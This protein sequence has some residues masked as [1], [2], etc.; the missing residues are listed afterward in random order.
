[1]GQ[2][3]NKIL[4]LETKFGLNS[5]SEYE[6]LLYDS[7]EIGCAELNLD[8]LYSDEDIKNIMKLLMY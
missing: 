1:M 8:D 3:N 7:D 5:D 2:K 4:L 6:T